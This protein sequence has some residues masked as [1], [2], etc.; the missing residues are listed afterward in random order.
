[1]T[2]NKYTCFSTALSDPLTR[3]KGRWDALF[4]FEY[5]MLQYRGFWGLLLKTDLILG[6]LSPHFAVHPN[7]YICSGKPLAK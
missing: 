1:M 5:I 7:F 6:R 3:N 4:S 2:L